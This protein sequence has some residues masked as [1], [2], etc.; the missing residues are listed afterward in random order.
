MSQQG[1]ARRPGVITF[2]GIV[3]YIQAALAVIAGVAFIVFRDSDRILESTNQT[4]NTLLGSGIGEIVVGV[5]IF[6]V[7]Q[8]LMS[9]SRGARL[10]VALVEGVRMGFAVW[11]MMTHHTTAAVEMGVVTLLIGFFV[12]WALYAHDASEAYFA[13]HG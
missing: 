3:M 5:V 11:L 4:S 6:L 10:L 8:A 1:I 13:E 9:G 12:I 2:I 7:A